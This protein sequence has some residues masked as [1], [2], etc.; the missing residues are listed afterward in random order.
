MLSPHLLEK[1][2]K[3]VSFTL[4]HEYNILMFVS[5]RSKAGPERLEAQLRVQTL[6]FHVKTKD[7]SNCV[8]SA[9]K[10]LGCKRA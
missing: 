1:Y 10:V 2:R 9:L 6:S 8:K 4:E 5:T 7:S 3:Y